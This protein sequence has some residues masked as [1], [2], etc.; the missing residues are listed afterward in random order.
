MFIVGLTGGIGSGKT[1]VSDIFE[2]CGITVVDADLCSRIVVEKGR[3]ALQKIAEHFGESILDDKG[4][5]D[6]ALL[7]KKIFSNPEEKKW[8]EN[9]LHPLIFEELVSQINASTS[10]YTLLVSPL[11]IESGQNTICNRLLVID[12]PESVQIERTLRRDNETREQID[13]IMRSQAS[14]QQ[15]LEKADDIIENTGSLDMLKSAVLALHEKYKQLAN[16]HKL[17]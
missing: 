11:L 9:L 4:N 17:E 1:A 7:R 5:L 10:P 3:P 13:S 6:R 8:L 15:R 12:V 2:Q 14:R 16:T